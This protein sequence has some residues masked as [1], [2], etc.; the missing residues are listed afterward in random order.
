MVGNTVKPRFKISK[1]IERS[2]N[3]WPKFWDFFEALWLKLHAE[4]AR[5]GR[6]IECETFHFYPFLISKHLI[7][8]YMAHIKLCF[9]QICFDFAN[10]FVH[11][12]THI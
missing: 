1:N 6:H 4:A 12:E 10:E 5:K 9:I 8:Q 3:F 11:K 2:L 7:K